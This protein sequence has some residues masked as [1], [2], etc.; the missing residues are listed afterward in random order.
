MDRRQD[1]LDRQTAINLANPA[2]TFWLDP[3]GVGK[4]GMA[5]WQRAVAM[6][7][8]PRILIRKGNKV[9]GS[10]F[11][12]WTIKAFLDGWHPT[13][14]RRQ[15]LEDVLYVGADLETTYKKD[16]S[17]RLREFFTDGDL[18]ARCHF[19][20]AKG[21]MLAGAR[22]IETPAGDMVTFV[23]GTQAAL[24]L[25]G[26]SYGLIIVNEPP[27]SHIWAEVMRAAAEHGATVLVNF[28]PLP[29]ESMVG[30]DDLVWLKNEVEK[31]PEP[32]TA[33]W[34]IH[35]VPLRPDTAPHR[36]QESIAQQIADMF[37]WER[38]QRR[39]AA[40]EGPA[41]ARTLA[42]W[43]DDQVWSG[44]SWDDL[45]GAA[46]GEIRL[47]LWADHGEL[48][49]HEVVGLGAWQ[50]RGRHASVWLVDEYVSPDRTTIAQDAGGVLRM[51]GRRGLTY[52]Q[53]DE[54]VG[55]VNTAGKSKLTTINDELTR[56]LAAQSGVRG[57]RFMPAQ[58]GP[59]SVAFGVR[60]I[61][62]ALG[63]GRSWVHERCEGLRRAARRW[64]G[65]D[66]D[67]K[68]WIDMWRYGA[69]PHLDHRR[70]ARVPRLRVG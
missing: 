6:D 39:D 40:W 7:P 53:I 41:P 15:R 21:F 19:D 28:T 45:P 16:V 43:T 29:P 17:R 31:E 18:S 26:A 70:S 61:D 50:G 46:G 5:P 64:Q 58:K 42:N 24:S 33:G 67:F 14:R 8:S 63:G 47:G 44:D 57:P 59:G 68:H 20:R 51:L 54:A 52:D 4:W 9:G 2:A 49:G 66:D 12:S 27:R 10:C 65:D 1:L 56:E 62:D 25:S 3:F 55:D 30:R 35:V 37:S 60:I 32:G 48:G 23:S 34:S 36:T 13:I 11:A 38:A 69:V 22:G